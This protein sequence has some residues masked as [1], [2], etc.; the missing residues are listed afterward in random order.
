MRTLLCCAA[1]A[2]CACADI[3]A[4]PSDGATV[5]EAGSALLGGASSLAQSSSAARAAGFSKPT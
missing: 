4:G 1:L 2:I 3:E 5:A